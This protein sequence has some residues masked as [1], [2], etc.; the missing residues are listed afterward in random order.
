ML[1]DVETGFRW[2]RGAFRWAKSRLAAYDEKSVAEQEA[3]QAARLEQ[4]RQNVVARA[5]KLRRPVPVKRR[6]SNPA[7]VEYSDGKVSYFY[8]DLAS[9]KAGVMGM[10]ALRSRYGVAPPAVVGEWDWVKV[11]RWL[12]DHPESGQTTP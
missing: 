7:V 10:D 5:V 1:D 12:S 9:Y 6:G 11:D 2:L 4:G 8:R 3:A